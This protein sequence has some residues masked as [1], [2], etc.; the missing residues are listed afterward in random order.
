MKSKLFV[1]SFLCMFL[2]LSINAQNTE[3]IVA[4]EQQTFGELMDMDLNGGK[5]FMDVLREK[6]IFPHI[7]DRNLEP[8]HLSGLLLAANGTPHRGDMHNRTAFAPMDVQCI[9]LYVLARTGIYLYDA[10]T[11]KLKIIDKIDARM[12]VSE[13]HSINKSPVI[14][15]YVINPDAM[16]VVKNEN[17]TNYAYLQAGSISQNVFLFCSSE[18][19]ATNVILDIKKEEV[20]KRLN[21]K[22]T[23]LLYIQAVGYRE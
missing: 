20:A 12:K 16:S 22:A 19:M 13:D 23:N 6:Y 18:D 15:L 11:H 9:T 21:T 17:L 10:E 5:P 2:S 3:A 1:V 4:D 14:L 7:S 8:H